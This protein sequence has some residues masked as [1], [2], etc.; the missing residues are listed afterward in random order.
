[1]L[2]RVI[3]LVIIL[4]PALAH[5]QDDAPKEKKPRTHQNVALPELI[6][7]PYLQAASDKSIVIRWRTSALARSRVSYGIVAGKLSANTDDATLTTE[8]SVK[9][10]GLTPHTKYYYSVGD[11][12]NVLQGD[13]ANYFYTLPVTGT[14]GVYRVSLIGDCGT[15]SPKQR[16]VRD[17]LLKYLGGNY[18]DAWLLLGDN[19][20][21]DATDAEYQSNFFNVYKDDLLK[22]YPLF[23]APG[24]H[25][26]HDLDY[27]SDV[28]QKN[29]Q[30]AY[31]QNFTMPTEG[32]SGGEPS[33]S[34]SYYSFDIGNAHFLSL[35]SYGEGK[36]GS[37]L[38]DVNGEEVKWIKKDL[39]KNKNKGWVVAYWHH[40]PY[41]MG[42]HNSDKEQEL[43][44]IRENF[45]K[46]LEK[47]G[48]D[49]IVCGHSHV[50]E[51]SKLMNGYYGPEDSFNADKHD[52][53][54]STG[55]YDGSANSCPYIKNQNDKP[56]IVYIVSGS[57][58]KTGGTQKSWPHA[59][60]Q[61]S[62]A[63]VTGSTLLEIQ[64]N[65]LDVKWI[66]ADG[67]I[68][69]HFTMMKNV[70]KKSV[71]KVKSGEPVTLTAS[72]IGNYKWNNNKGTTRSISVNP[73]Q[74]KTVYT[75]S[76]PSNCLQ[77]T[78]EVNVN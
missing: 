17:A 76:D 67:V 62:N 7:G 2:R 45:I 78:F 40:P 3:L 6:R 56:G 44:K 23:P 26:Y 57:G 42:T 52:V 8:H 11:I 27:G 13:T 28:V 65:R 55:L 12:K 30:T 10:T 19:A 22:K 33:H 16:G 77:D 15:N 21:P 74:G 1:M 4:L 72:F 5:G 35:D 63:T 37:R 25:D 29:H 49:L 31:Y 54:Q 53:S 69:D 48:V 75:V 68:R 66:C 36:D 46:I 47:A 20:Y 71:I 38:Y 14:E 9:L 51:R 43:V 39:E 24:N 58:G 60:M 73:P 32:E 64:G 18:L 61:Y 59:A 70:N 50:Y 34:Q 41:T